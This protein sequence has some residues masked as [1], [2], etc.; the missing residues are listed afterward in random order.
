MGTSTTASFELAR[1]TRA[2]EERDSETQV[3]MYAPDAMVMI[4]DRITQPGSPRVL[5]GV[6]EIR[7]WIEDVNGRDMTHKV[8][9]SVS[10]DHAGALA[11]ACRYSDGTNVLCTTVFE[12]EGGAISRQTIVQAWDETEPPARQ[13]TEHKSFLRSGR[14]PRV[15]QRQGRDPL[16]RRC[17]DRPAD[18]P[19][20]LAVVQR[21]QADRRYGEL[22]GTALP[23][24]R[25][26]P[27]RDP[28]E[29]LH[30]NHR[31]S[32]VMS[33]LCLV[34]TMPGWWAMSRSSS[35]TS[36]APAATPSAPEHAGGRL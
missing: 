25:L 9:H 27:T 3:S 36:T 22:R 4:A 5:K 15:S 1:F 23:V 35:S 10:D 11:E 2:L 16:N 24:P 14:D 28:D 19:A 20:R 13:N 8:L 6:A 30:R 21:R 7:G 17:R 29:R 18:L 33:P 34:G 12:L 26:R 32:Q 31:W